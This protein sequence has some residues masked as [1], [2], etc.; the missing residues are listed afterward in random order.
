MGQVTRKTSRIRKRQPAGLPLHTVMPMCLLAALGMVLPFACE[1]ADQPL[2]YRVKAAFLLNFTKFI[3]WPV[4]AFAAQDSPIDICIMG[5]DPFG[6]ALD[7][8]VAGEVV[9]GRRVAI[10][11]I[12]H[13]PLPKTCAVL[14][15]GRPERDV[16]KL[17]LGLGPGVLTV[18]E[19]EGFLR[20]GGMIAFVIENR[21]VRFE[22]N[23]TAA[24]KGGI[25]L[26]SRLLNVAKPV[27]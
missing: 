7:E 18:G 3:E 1:G 14:F 19:G 9:N 26:S 11:R 25:K 10:Q 27:E 16:A 5:E 24:E 8:I 2:E 21:R 15:A 12:K 23:R 17:L 6:G 4:A 20:D 22:V 13:V